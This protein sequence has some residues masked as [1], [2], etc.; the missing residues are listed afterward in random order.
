MTEFLRRHESEVRIDAVDEAPQWLPNPGPQ[1]LALVSQADEIFYGGQAGGGKTDLIIGLAL[2]IQHRS[3]IFRREAKQVQGIADRVA[4]ILGNRNGFN[5]ST[6]VWRLAGGRQLQLAGCKDPGDEEKFQGI[7]HDL[8]GFDEICHFNEKQYLFLSGWNRS[9]RSGQRCRVVATGNPPT[10]EEGQWVVRRWAAWL[11]PAHPN[12][13]KPGEIRWYIRVADIDTEVAGPGVVDIDGETYTPRSRT[14]IPAGLADNPHLAGSGYE[15]VID[16]MPEP[17]RTQLK[18][19]D[20]GVGIKDDPWQVIPR[21]WV[22]AAIERGRT[23][24]KPETPLSALGVDVARGGQASTVLSERYDTW[25]EPLK[26]YTG[27]QTDTGPKVAAHVLLVLDGSKAPVNIDV[28]GIGA[29]AYDSLTGNC[30]VAAVNAALPSKARDRSGKLGMRNL[31]AEMWWKFREALDPE[32]GDNLSLPDDSQMLA[33]LCAPRFSVT[34]AGILIEPKEDICKRL[35]RTV[36]KGDAVVMAHL[37][38]GWTGDSS[39]IDFLKE[40][41]GSTTQ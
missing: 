17:L 38:P 34:A 36:D 2:T 41:Y 1:S 28:I 20:F 37:M 15:A 12:P 40:R 10:T 33:D 4:E 27:E 8:K 5:S 24:K 39:I 29:S 3:I 9:A 6:G 7:P 23:G 18:R 22:L 30:N 19:G 26:V 11:D 14:F 31:R 35:G 16:A 25:F 13:A 21:A 32:H